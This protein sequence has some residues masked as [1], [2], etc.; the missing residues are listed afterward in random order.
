MVLP[1]ATASLASSVPLQEDRGVAAVVLLKRTGILN[2]LPGDWSPA[3]PQRVSAYGKDFTEAASL[4]VRPSLG[5][6]ATVERSRRA[7]TALS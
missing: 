3:R 2:R 6:C 5:A 4:S 1:N 7:K